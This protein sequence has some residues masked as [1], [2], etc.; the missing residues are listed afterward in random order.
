MRIVTGATGGMG[1]SIVEA[2]LQSGA[3]VIGIDVG[4]A[5]THPSWS[6]MHAGY[7]W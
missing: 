2:L 5:P 4:E 6:K 1:L 3:D 7:I